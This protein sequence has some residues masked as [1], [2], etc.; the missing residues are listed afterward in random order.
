MMD[1]TILNVAARKLAEASQTLLD[2]QEGNPSLRVLRIA[3]EANALACEVLACGL[4]ERA[5]E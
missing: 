4:A 2:A 1:Q 5:G 3:T